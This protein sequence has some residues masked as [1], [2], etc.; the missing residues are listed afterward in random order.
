MTALARA[1]RVPHTEQEYNELV[2]LLDNLRFSPAGNHLV[3]HTVRDEA[4]AVG[5]VLHAAR[6]DRHDLD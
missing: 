4:I 6:D 3:F 2:E 5:R 1:V